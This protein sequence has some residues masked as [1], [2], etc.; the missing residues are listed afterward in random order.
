M[1]SECPGCRQMITG[2]FKEAFAAEGFLDMA[3]VNLFPYGNASEK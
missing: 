3:E 2:S 1:E